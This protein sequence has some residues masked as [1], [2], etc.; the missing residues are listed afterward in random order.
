M[1]IS[2][3]TTDGS[4]VQMLTIVVGAPWPIYKL[5]TTNQTLECLCIWHQAF[6]LVSEPGVV[7]EDGVVSEGGVV[8]EGGVVSEGGVVIEDRVVSEPGVVSEVGWS[9]RVVWSLRIGRARH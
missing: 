7:I 5:I 4:V 2:R 8:I 6:S 9:V 3:F 1:D